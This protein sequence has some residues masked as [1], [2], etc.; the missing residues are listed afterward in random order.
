M[1]N[2]IAGVN[3][4]EIAQESLPALQ[5]LFAPLKSV[6]TDF[7]DDVASRGESV[8]TRFASKPSAQDLSSG[9]GATD[10][11]MTS[12]T[13]NLNNFKGFVYKFNDLER[14]KSS[15][16]LG[17]LFIEPAMQAVGEAVFSDLWNLV[18]SSNF[19]SSSVI[20]ASNFDRNDLIDLGTSLT[21][22]KKAPATNR[23]LLANP[24]YYGSLV[25]TLNSAEI[26]GITSDKAEASVPR[27]AKFDTYESNVIDANGE[28]LACFA[29][30]KSSLL[31][32]S[33]VVDATGATEAG[34]EVENV[35]IP[36]LGLPVQFRRFYNPAEGT[37]NYSMGVLYG[38]SAGTDMGIRVTSA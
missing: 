26:Q 38:V 16:N 29:G 8:T 34:V 5:S 25:K 31:F 18:S 32:A 36:E 21:A 10:V 14:S 1:A 12:K 3:L 23:F 7:S 9:Y 27:I 24:S 19:S 2:T 15:V 30:H 22:D 33:R 35:V 17:S 11:E 20:T 13:I 4:A 28:D 6:M 37:L